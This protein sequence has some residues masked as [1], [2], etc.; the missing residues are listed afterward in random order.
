MSPSDKSPISFCVNVLRL[1]KKGMPVR[2]TADAVQR[3]ALAAAHDL[4]EVRSLEAELIVT[5]WKRDGVRVAGQVTADIVQNC[6]VTLEPIDAHVDEP[7]DGVFA[8]VG[9]RLTRPERYEAGELVIDAEGPDL[10]ELFTGDEVDVGQ[11]VE[12]HFA[13]AIDPYPRRGN[14]AL[15]TGTP[16]APDEEEERGPLF[17]KLRG[18]RHES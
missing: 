11:F 6:V 1:P 5:A 15:P 12:E 8:P 7:L 17:E 4:A 9:S 2:I 18:L 13:L 16:D 10:P 14:V 3:A